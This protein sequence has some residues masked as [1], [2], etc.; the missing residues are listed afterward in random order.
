M[1]VVTALAYRTQ[2]AYNNMVAATEEEDIKA[3]AFVVGEL[4]TLSGHL[5][6]A[7]ETGRRKMFQL[8]REFLQLLSLELTL[9]GGLL[10]EMI[11]QI[12]LPEMLIPKCLDV[13]SKIANG[14]KDLIRIVV[15]VITELR[16][17]EEEEDADMVCVMWNK[18][19]R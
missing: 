10:G 9:T 15:D 5:D 16:A 13:L 1:P 18:E 7:D 3:H 14:E 11:S 12:N 8:T 6:Y 2:D 17:G 19:R 4:L